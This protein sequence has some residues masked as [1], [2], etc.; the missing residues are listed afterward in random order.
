MIFKA[1]IRLRLIGFKICGNEDDGT[2]SKQFHQIDLKMIIFEQQHIY[3]S[4]YFEPSTRI[5]RYFN[6]L[7]NFYR[8]DIIFAIITRCKWLKFVNDWLLAWIQLSEW[9]TYAYCAWTY[10]PQ[11]F[12]FQY[13][14]RVFPYHITIHCTKRYTNIQ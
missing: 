10:C 11:V 9:N 12:F 8:V 14:P 2:Y 4:V 5:W 6:R 3:F 13:Q 1:D 7:R